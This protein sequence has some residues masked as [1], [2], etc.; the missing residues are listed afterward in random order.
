MR[1][2][3]DVMASLRRTK[4]VILAGDLNLVRRPADCYY[5]ERRVDLARALS[6]PGVPPYPFGGA[7]PA[8][9]GGA[10]QS[11]RAA[12]RGAAQRHTAFTA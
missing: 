12:G 5:T 2:L 9:G 4:P 8:E 3:R 6:E 11:S 10:G 7:A 1:R